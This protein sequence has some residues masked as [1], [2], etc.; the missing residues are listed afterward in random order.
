MGKT[1]SDINLANVF[2]S[3]S[4]KATEIRAIINEWD[5]IKVTDFCT[6]NETIKK[7]ANL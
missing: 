4:P 6:E 3:Q 1:F 7:K 5:V 2:L